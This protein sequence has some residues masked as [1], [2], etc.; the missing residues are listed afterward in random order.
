M[1]DHLYR[2]AIYSP[3]G[4]YRYVLRIIWNPDIPPVAVIGLNP[5]TAT[6][7]QDDPTVRRCIRFAEEWGHGGLIMLNLFAL[8]STDPRWLISARD[9]IGPANA[10]FLE[11]QTLFA[12][13]VIAAWGA[14]VDRIPEQAERARQSLARTGRELECLG[15]TAAGHPRHPLYLRA[16]TTP[17]PFSMGQPTARPAYLPPPDPLT[18]PHVQRVATA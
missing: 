3:D 6:E 2:S 12:D 1:G 17:Q 9:P 13:R 11:Y 10:A 4:V 16:D 18:F 8:R 5:S 7:Q 14:H 15:L